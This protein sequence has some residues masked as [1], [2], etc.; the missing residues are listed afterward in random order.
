MIVTQVCVLEKWS[1]WL[2]QTS[3]LSGQPCINTIIGFEPFFFFCVVLVVVVV[4]VVGLLWKQY[5]AVLWD[6]SFLCK[7]TPCDSIVM[8][9]QV[10]PRVIVLIG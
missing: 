10:T 6:P 1:I 8:P 2:F 9:K 5:S 3:P 4:V 7:I